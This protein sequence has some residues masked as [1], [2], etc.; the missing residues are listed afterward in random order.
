MIFYFQEKQLKNFVPQ[1]YRCEK[2]NG[3]SYVVLKDVS[4]DFPVS[5]RTLL[6]IK[7]GTRTFSVMETSVKKRTDLYEKIKNVDAGSLTSDEHADG[8]VTKKRY[9][10]FRDMQSSS[11]SLG[12]RLEGTRLPG[13]NVTKGY[14]RLHARDQVQEVLLR[15]VGNRVILAQLCT[16]LRKL[17][18]AIEE[19]NFFKTHE[20]IGNSILVVHDG[21]RCGLWLIDF[22]N[23]LRLNASDSLDHRAESSDGYLKGMDELISVLEEKL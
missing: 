2:H 7:M 1:Y 18:I 11:A 23:T 12:F 3:T 14:E 8:A 16:K 21:V 17:K 5:R 6:D 10:S 15:H 22:A 4:F 19:S 13:Q 20:V 9:M